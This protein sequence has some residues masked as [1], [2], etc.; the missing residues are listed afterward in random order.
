VQSTEGV[1]GETMDGIPWTDACG[2]GDRSID[3][4]TNRSEEARPKWLSAKNR[5]HHV[6]RGAIGAFNGTMRFRVVRCRDMVL[7]VE[8][9]AGLLDDCVCKTGTTICNCLHRHSMATD[10]LFE[11]RCGRRG[12]INTLSRHKLDKPGETVHED[13]NVALAL[14]FTERPDIIEEDTLE[15]ILGHGRVELLMWNL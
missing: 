15:L 5:A 3:S 14:T 1:G 13:E 8:E 9:L 7:Y 12:S 4:E 6:E 11:Q 10:P 2:A